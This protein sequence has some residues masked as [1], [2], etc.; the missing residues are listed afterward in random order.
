[1]IDE[2]SMVRLLTFLHLSEPNN[3]MKFIEITP[4]NYDIETSKGFFPVGVRF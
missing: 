1:M 2:D 3:T 4:E